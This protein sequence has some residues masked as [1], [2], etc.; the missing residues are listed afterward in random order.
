MTWMDR[1]LRSRHILESDLKE[2]EKELIKM[3]VNCAIKEMINPNGRASYFDGIQ[4]GIA[5]TLKMLKRDDI[6]ELIDFEYG[7]HD[8][9]V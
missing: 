4:T 5:Q 3:Y 9:L 7:C 2:N 6:W 1:D 8:E